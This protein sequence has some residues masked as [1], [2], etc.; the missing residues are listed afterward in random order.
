MTVTGGSGSCGQQLYRP[1]FEVSISRPGGCP[2]S[3]HPAP[4]GAMSAILLNLDGSIGRTGGA[5][6]ILTNATIAASTVPNTIS[7]NVQASLQQATNN[8]GPIVAPPT[9]VVSPPQVPSN[10]VQTTSSQT[11]PIVSN[12]IPP[13]PPTPPQPVVIQIAGLVK[14]APHGSTLGFTDQSAAGRVPYTGSITYPAGSDLQNGVAT[15]ADTAGAVFTL[16]PLTAG[17]TTNVTATATTANSPATGTATE[18]SDGDF[19]FANLNATTGGQSIFAF[20]GT[21]VAQSF[22]APQPNAQ[23]LAFNVLPDASLGSNGQPQTIPFLPAAFGG[24]MANAAVSPLYLATIANSPFGSFNENNNPDGTAPHYLQASLAVNGQGA[25]QSS[26]LVI[27]TGGFDTSNAGSVY[28]SGPVRGVVLTSAT[29]PL[30]GIEAG[31]ATVPDANGNNLFGGSTIDGFVLDQNQYSNG[32]L[33]LNTA[34]ALPVSQ[35]YGSGGQ[36]FPTYAF[37][38]PVTATSL[39]TNVGVTRSALNETGFFGGIMELGGFY[40]A[41]TSY[42]L[43]GIT[44]VQTFPSDNRVAAT[45]VGTDPFTPAQSNLSSLV[46]QFGNDTTGSRSNLSKTTFIDNNIY[47]AAVEN[48]NIAS[49]IT[50]TNGTTTTLP[51][52]ESGSTLFPRLAMVTSATLGPNANSWMPAGVTPCSCQY[53]QWGYWTGRV[54]IPNTPEASPTYSRVDQA[55]INTWTRWAAA[56]TR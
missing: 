56:G 5:T 30:I 41:P 49:T 16:S 14:V 25:S 15:G 55:A 33:S 36:P 10:Q 22:F 9:P 39:P 35:T 26:A 40:G 32:A 6:T 31:S 54:G 53:L 13:A 1:G 46:L 38:Q 47:A 8:A 44:S 37:N 21:P 48:P 17:A 29:G 20:G 3:P 7:N 27:M 52:E 23:I 24:T 4:L 45:F 34:T 43:T 11:Q 42:A 12:P 2:D 51:T 18:T 50:T 28:G 19:F